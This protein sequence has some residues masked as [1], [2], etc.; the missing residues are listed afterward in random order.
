MLMFLRDASD[1]FEFD[2]PGTPAVNALEVHAA[3]VLGPQMDW[4]ARVDA[5][6]LDNIGKYRRYNPACLRD[7]L[8]VIRNKS[9]HYRDLPP[10]VQALLGPLPDGF[11]RYFVSRFPQL[12]IRVYGVVGELC[13]HE[14][15][16]RQYFPA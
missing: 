12:L 11:L 14:A 16:L 7:L 13:R 5:A 4:M 6:L 10:A 8:R 3:S 9:H 1:R 2:K 15:P